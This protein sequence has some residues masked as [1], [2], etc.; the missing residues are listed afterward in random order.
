MLDDDTYLG[1]EN[2]FNLFTLRKNNEGFFVSFP[3]I[4]IALLSLSASTQ[5]ERGRLE[6]AGLFHLGDFVNRMMLTLFIFASSS[7]DLSFS[8]AVLW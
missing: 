6:E 8:G 3:Y 7:R 4:F 1:S 2:S 5:E